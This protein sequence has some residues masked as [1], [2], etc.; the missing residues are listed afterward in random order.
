MLVVPDFRIAALLSPFLLRNFFP[1][2]Q[3]PF[4]GSFR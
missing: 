1:R 4:N 3:I 2:P